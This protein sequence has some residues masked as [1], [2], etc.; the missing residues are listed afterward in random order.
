MSYGDV[1][2]GKRTMYMVTLYRV[3]DCIVTISFGVH[4]V[5]WLF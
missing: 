1:L 5:L 3:L 4:L 2:G